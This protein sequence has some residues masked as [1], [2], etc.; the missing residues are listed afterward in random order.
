MQFY[1]IVSN[2]NE[3]TKAQYLPVFFKDVD[4]KIRQEFA[5]LEF[6]FLPC[7]GEKCSV[8]MT[9]TASSVPS[10]MELHQVVR[11]ES[12]L[13]RAYATRAYFYSVQVA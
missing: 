10:K 7:V 9:W 11:G 3:T 12:L 4:M 2:R 5:G 13:S 1:R 8:V 6:K